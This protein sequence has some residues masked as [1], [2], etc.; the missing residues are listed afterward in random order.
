MWP[1][2]LIIHHICQR[3]WLCFSAIV[4]ALVALSC[5]AQARWNSRLT[6]G[7]I[8]CMLDTKLSTIVNQ[9]IDKFNEANK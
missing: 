8:F 6:F 4:S 7:L 5:L 1:H 2:C 3:L 9:T